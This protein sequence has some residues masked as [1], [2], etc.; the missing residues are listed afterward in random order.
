MSEALYTRDILRLAVSI[1]HEQRLDR[2]DGSAEVRSRT[3]GSVVTADVIVADNGCLTDLGLNISA[4]A[5]GQASAAILASEAVGRAVS[6]I[7]ATRAALKSFLDGS[8]ES[9]GEWANMEKLRAAKDHQGRHA[10][11]LLPYDALIAAFAD[12]ARRKAA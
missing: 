10:A 7:A 6:D 3:C 9:P 1:P 2:P 5:L 12:A 4:C 11:I 8:A